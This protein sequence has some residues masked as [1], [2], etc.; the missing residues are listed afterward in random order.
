MQPKYIVLGIIISCLGC[1]IL[2][3]MNNK[4]TQNDLLFNYDS[5][6]EENNQ[7]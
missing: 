3:T 1:Y 6:E 5:E 7:E 4:P 2:E